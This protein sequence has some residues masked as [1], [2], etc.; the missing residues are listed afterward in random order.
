M[1]KGKKMPDITIEGS[2]EVEY[3]F[4][5]G[6]IVPRKKGPEGPVERDGPR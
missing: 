6:K 4:R 2:S 5:D 1:K 3:E